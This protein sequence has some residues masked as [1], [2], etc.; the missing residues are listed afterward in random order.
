MSGTSAP[1]TATK[2]NGTPTTPVLAYIAT[3][4][5]A[6]TTSG[7]EA[8]TAIDHNDHAPTDRYNPNRG[9]NPQPPHRRCWRL[10]SR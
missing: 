9:L 10:L 8:A 3:S 5:P 2:L 7:E 1:A 6:S 4:P